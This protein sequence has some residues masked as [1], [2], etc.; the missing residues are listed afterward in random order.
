MYLDDEYLKNCWGIKY[1]E[2]I[3]KIRRAVNETKG[4]Y[5]VYD[6]EVITAFFFSTSSGLTENSE[7]VFISYLP[8]LR[9]VDSSFEEGVSPVFEEENKYSLDEFYDR[10]GLEY[11]EELDYEVTRT[12]STG[13][14]KEIVING[15]EYSGDEIEYLLSLRSSLRCLW[16]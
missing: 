3:S 2:N 11:S 15:K 4:E 9:S 6:G 10:L 14:V 8:Y 16:T 13:R 12:T 5:I 7:E 1:G